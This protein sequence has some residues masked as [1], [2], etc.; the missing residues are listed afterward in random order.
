VDYRR[1]PPNIHVVISALPKCHSRS[2]GHILVTR[3]FIILVI[4]SLEYIDVLCNLTHN[5]ANYYRNHQ[6][7]I[8]F[9][10]KAAEVGRICASAVSQ[11]ESVITLVRMESNGMDF[12]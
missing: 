5:L 9:Y 11:N 1:L 2:A 10:E 3:L 12:C 6:F 8:R 4:K 7:H